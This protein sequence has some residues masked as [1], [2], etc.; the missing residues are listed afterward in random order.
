MT[1]FFFFSYA[2]NDLHGEYLTTFYDELCTE[3]SQQLGDRSPTEVGFLDTN[4]P[5]GTEWMTATAQGLAACKV[6]IPV[7]SP[8]YFLSTYC[9]KEWHCFAHRIANSESTSGLILPVWW[10]PPPGELPS[11]AA[12]LQDSRASY[13]PAHA[14]HGLK[15][16]RKLSRHRDDY[17][18]FL[19]TFVS[20]AIAVARAHRGTSG[21]RPPDLARS[22]SAFT[23][24]PGVPTRSNV[25][26]AKAGGGPKWIRIIIVAGSREQMHGH[27]GNL[28]HY[29]DEWYDW[30]PYFPSFSDPMGSHT[31]QLATAPG[32]CTGLHPADHNLVNLVRDAEAKREIVLL[33]VDAW[34]T[35]IDDLADALASFDGVHFDNSAVL[36][37]LNGDDSE[38]AEQ[39]SDLWRALEVHLGRSIRNRVPLIT[40]DTSTIQAF[41][42]SVH[43]AIVQ[44]RGRVVKNHQPARS[45]TS[46]HKTPIQRPQLSG[47]SGMVSA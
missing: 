36:I 15:Y 26:D 16:L 40:A 14:E 37:P 9:G 34:A 45:A 25:G 33:I 35:R 44:T 24:S 11:C 22:P 47:P 30:R 10:I 6:F 27:R 2:R 41:D 12:A 19:T 8:S 31:Q 28:V 18:R 46:D 21:G 3:F 39:L 38:T 1:Y 32:I 29:G 17:E 5:S 4:L 23:I 43:A 42:K 7:Y 13:G 20:R